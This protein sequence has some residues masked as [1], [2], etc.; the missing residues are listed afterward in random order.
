MKV[1]H[2]LITI[3]RHKAHRGI[4]THQP[5]DLLGEHGQRR[6][7]LPDQGDDHLLLQLRLLPWKH[8]EAVAASAASWQARCPTIAGLVPVLV[9]WRL[10]QLPHT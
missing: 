9:S 7:L 1:N 4:H 8:V 6:R 10:E 5:A 3:L 2:G